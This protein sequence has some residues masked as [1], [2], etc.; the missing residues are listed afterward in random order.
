MISSTL[1]I[2]GSSATPI[3]KPNL[4]KEKSEPPIG[5]NTKTPKIAPNSNPA[6]T[7]AAASNEVKTDK[8]TD[9]K[10]DKKSTFIL[11]SGALNENLLAQLQERHEREKK[12]A[13]NI[14]QRTQPHV[15][16]AVK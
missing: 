3:S 2:Q 11:E 9:K 7:K 5:A 1:I 13:E 15:I 10:T 8:T 14:R 4:K 12:A 16:S 6:S